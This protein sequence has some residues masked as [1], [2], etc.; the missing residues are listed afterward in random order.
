VRRIEAVAGLTAYGSA[1]TDAARLAVLAD[2]DRITHWRTWKK[3]LDAL[4][5]QQKELEKALKAAT[6]REAAGRSKES[7]RQGGDDQRRAGDSSRI[8]ARW[9]RIPRSRS[10]SR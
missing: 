2:Q 8:S 9:M 3:K 7:A 10:R 4:L 1:L 6:Q 5:A